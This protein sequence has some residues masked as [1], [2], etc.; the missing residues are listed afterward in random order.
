MLSGAGGLLF[1]IMHGAVT[2]M[3]HCRALTVHHVKKA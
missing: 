1:R 2:T 3:H